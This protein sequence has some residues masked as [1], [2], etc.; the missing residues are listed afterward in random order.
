[1]SGDDPGIH[2]GLNRP[3]DLTQDPIDKTH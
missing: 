2:A 3:H 1:M